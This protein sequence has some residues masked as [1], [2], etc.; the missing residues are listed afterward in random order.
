MFVRRCSTQCQLQERAM[1]LQ[2][3]SLQPCHCRMST[4][5]AAAAAAVL[6]PRKT[7]P[8][9]S[10]ARSAMVQY[11]YSA[12][13]PGAVCTKGTR[14]K[15]HATNTMVQY[16]YSAPGPGAVPEKGPSQHW[17]TKCHKS[18]AEP[19][20]LV[21]F[22]MNKET[23]DPGASAAWWEGEPCPCQATNSRRFWGWSGHP[24]SGSQST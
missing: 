17:C 7:K 3:L 21:S 12:P 5:A 2:P 23:S 15:S 22:P 19:P 11:L 14:K 6:M 20:V 9:E 4:Y 24:R 16:L 8:V 18:T 1:S 13:G 10:N